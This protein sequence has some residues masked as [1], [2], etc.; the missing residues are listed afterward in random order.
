MKDLSEKVIS[1][2]SCLRFKVLELAG[3]KEPPKTPIKITYIT[4]EVRLAMID[5]ESQFSGSMTVAKDLLASRYLSK[6][7]TVK[8]VADMFN[9]SETTIRRRQKMLKYRINLVYKML[10]EQV[11]NYTPEML[12]DVLEEYYGPKFEFDDNGEV[13]VI[14]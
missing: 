7:Y 5:I 14:V 6:E 12:L 1:F 13:K 9:V 4:T 8:E 11:T 2:L 10:S 3:V